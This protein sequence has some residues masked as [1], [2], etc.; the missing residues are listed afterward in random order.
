ML[1]QDI[2]SWNWL[3]HSSLDLLD[4]ILSGRRNKASATTSQRSQEALSVIP[5]EPFPDQKALP[6]SSSNGNDQVRWR[7]VDGTIL[8]SFPALG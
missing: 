5:P 2:G 8:A 7:M 3:A 1:D 6:V 4:V